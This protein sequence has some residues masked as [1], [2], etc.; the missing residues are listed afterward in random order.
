MRPWR[1][2]VGNDIPENYWPIPEVWAGMES[3]PEIR[4]TFWEAMNWFWDYFSQVG[5]REL[6]LVESMGE[7]EII[8]WIL[9]KPYFSLSFYSGF[10]AEIFRVS[11][12][13]H[14]KKKN[15]VFNF[16]LI[17]PP[18]F[19]NRGKNLFK[20]SVSNVCPR[21]YC[22]QATFLMDPSAVSHFS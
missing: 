22:L 6:Q 14:H 2:W 5:F 1:G 3:V 10:T 11:K 21:D 20:F 19:T 8:P 13:N 7:R 18:W 4:V 16:I 17:G 15:L 9:A 12:A